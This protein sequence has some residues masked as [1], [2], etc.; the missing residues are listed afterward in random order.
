MGSIVVYLFILGHNNLESVGRVGLD[1]SFLGESHFSLL[2]HIHIFFASSVRVLFEHCTGLQNRG[3][4]C[5]ED[6]NEFETLRTHAFSET[7]RT[8]F[9]FCVILNFLLH[10]Q[11]QCWRADFAYSNFFLRALPARRGSMSHAVD[12]PSRCRW[13]SL[14]SPIRA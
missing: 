14:S 1:P 13:N 3:P 4:I 12:F 8:S 7:S 11:F 6:E 9:S 2:P 5:L 10:L